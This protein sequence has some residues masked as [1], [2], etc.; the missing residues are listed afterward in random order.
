MYILSLKL[1]ILLTKNLNTT[2]IHL[3]ITTISQ[4]DTSTIFNCYYNYTNTTHMINFEFN[5]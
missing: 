5:V 2:T 3:V 1:I 4:K